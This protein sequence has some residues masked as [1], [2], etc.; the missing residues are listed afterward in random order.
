MTKRIDRLKTIYR[1]YQNVIQVLGINLVIFLIFWGGLLHNQYNADTIYYR[2]QPP[3]DAYTFRL[4]EGRYVL[5]FLYWFLPAIG[6]NVANRISVTTFF[7]ILMF[8]IAVTINYFALV[9]ERKVDYLKLLCVDLV[10]IN[11]FFVELLMFAETLFGVAYIFAALAVWCYSNKK[12]LGFA[13]SVILAACT[14]QYTVIYVAIVLLFFIGFKYDFRLCKESVLESFLVTVWN[15]LVAVCDILSARLLAVLGVLHS[16]AVEE[17]SQ[18]GGPLGE[19]VIA[20]LGDTVDIWRNCKDL[21]LGKWIFLLVSAFIVT[22]I[23]LICIQCRDWNKLGYFSILF[24]V[25][26]ILRIFIPCTRAQFNNPPRFAFSYYLVQGLFLLIVFYLLNVHEKESA[27]AKMLLGKKLVSC[28]VVLYVMIQLLSVQDIVNNKYASKAI[29]ETFVRL[30]YQKV[31]NYEAETGVTV[32]KFASA[33][34]IDCRDAYEEIGVA[35]YSVNEK[36]LG[37]ATWSIVQAVTGREFERIPMD[38]D[39]YEKYF[40]GRNWDYLNL[41]EQLVILDDTAYWCIY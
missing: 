21:L 23:L 33:N 5:A 20:V 19:K 16:E 2:F 38:Q 39:V 1:K 17:E 32:T 14:Y 12:Y 11:V 18:M 34:D 35:S 40:A 4:E 26:Y 30:M 29:D 31:Q 37:K 27:S 15:I 28:V 8:V 24:A 10:C 13:I 7:N 36:I 9:K 41:D 22:M 25:T 6:I 3:V